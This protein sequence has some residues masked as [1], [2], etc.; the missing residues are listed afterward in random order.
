MAQSVI[1]IPGMDTTPA[2]SDAV[3]E[4]EP[5]IFDTLAHILTP[6]FLTNV[7]LTL[8]TL[9]ILVAVYIGLSRG[10]AR[11][12]EHR[13][14]YRFLFLRL[15]RWTYIP[16]S[17]LLLIQQMGYHLGSLWTVVSTT[18][19]MVAIGFVAVWSVLSNVLATFLIMGTRLFA[20]G[21]EV[22]LLEPAAKEGTVRGTV[23]D[24]D[25]FFTT[26]SHTAA[27]GEGQI[28]TKIPNNVFFQKAT[29]VRIG[30]AKLQ[31]ELDAE[32]EREQAEQTSAANTAQA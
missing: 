3:T 4:N 12:L 17:M 31:A 9:L 22:E 24:L 18:L 16:F 11:V 15:L 1:M 23:S 14:K 27:N 28:W 21:D 7:G 2:P 13:P 25:L 5:G 19:A 6:E 8:F 32:R 20:V 10:L 30:G 29:R 26:I